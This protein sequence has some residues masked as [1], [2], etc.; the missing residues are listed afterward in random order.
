MG[1]T[2][3]APASSP[4]EA[5]RTATGRLTITQAI[6]KVMRQAGRPLAIPDI[7][8]GII[9]SNLYEFKADDPVHIVRNEVRRHSVGLDYPSASPTKLFRITEQGFYAP[10]DAPIKHPSLKRKH[11]RKTR[12]HPDSLRVFRRQHEQYLV[13]FRTRVSDEL[14]RLHPKQFERFCVIC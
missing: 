7:Y 6:L 13:Q 2:G 11:I 14:K 5:R 10:L 9:A 12:N 1:T 4:T 3:V 8:N